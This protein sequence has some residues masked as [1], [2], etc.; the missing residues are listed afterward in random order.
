MMK[1]DEKGSG[2]GIYYFEIMRMGKTLQGPSNEYI[3]WKI[4]VWARDARGARTARSNPQNVT[5]RKYG[6]LS[7]GIYSVSL[8]P[9]K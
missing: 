8:P 9:L 4:I 6:L 2:R 3:L 5:T 7:G 1:N